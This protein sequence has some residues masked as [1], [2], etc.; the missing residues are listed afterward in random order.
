MDVSV[1]CVK[2]VRFFPWLL[3]EIIKRYNPLILAFQKATTGILSAL[4]CAVLRFLKF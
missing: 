1:A 4:F 3:S 2:T